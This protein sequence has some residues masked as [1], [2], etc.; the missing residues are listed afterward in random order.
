MKRTA[1]VMVPAFVALWCVGA[2]AAELK[3]SD[4]VRPPGK[5]E[6]AAASFPDVP[7]L[8]AAR[9]MPSWGSGR[10]G[11]RLENRTRMNVYVPPGDGPFPCVIFVHGGAYTG[12]GKD[13]FPNHWAISR[14]SHGMK[15]AL[16]KG[17]VAVGPN[18]I[19]GRGIHPQVQRDFKELVRHL[20]ANAAKYRIDP[21]RIAANGSSAGGWLITSAGLTTADDYGFESKVNGESLAALVEDPNAWKRGHDRRRD[22]K[23]MLEH[24]PVLL[25]SFDELDPRHPQVSSRLNALV[26]D[27]AQQMTMASPDDP[28]MLSF[29]GKG[30]KSGKWDEQA[31]GGDLRLVELSNQRTAGKPNFHLPEPTQQVAAADGEGT[32]TLNERWFQFLDKVMN[33]DAARTPAA[34]A[35]P[36]RRLFKDAVDVTFATA[37]PSTAVHYTLDGSDPTAASPRATE[38]LRLDATTTVKFIAI[39]PVMKPSGVGSATFIKGQPLP[40]VEG[41][42]TL[43][44]ATVGRP[45]EV[46]FTAEGA[47]QWAVNCQHRGWKSRK[48]RWPK[49][50]GYAEYMR[51]MTTGAAMQIGLAFDTKTGQLKGVPDRHGT[52]VLQVAAARDPN[53]PAGFRTWT[54]VVK[55]Q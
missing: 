45:Y 47:T 8:D 50:E 22:A 10:D 1:M 15:L 48:I 39:A 18:Y 13:P 11:P 46:Q 12:G 14:E 41:P 23:G 30:A 20:R 21:N 35:R 17:Y 26:F 9:D 34:E 31:A 7:Y 44:V 32:V 49:Q 27:F 55:P 38:P 51:F 42:K 37:S 3:A 5:I 16:Q 24:G 28:V 43:P 33:S 36:N 19:L 54:L 53:S 4:E 52:Y 40:V 6:T 29:K 25:T 2:K